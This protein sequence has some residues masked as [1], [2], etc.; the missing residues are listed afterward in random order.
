MVFNLAFFGECPSHQIKDRIKICIHKDGVV[1]TAPDANINTGKI[2]FGK[3]NANLNTRQINQL[4]SIPIR[5]ASKAWFYPR[6]SGCTKLTS[7]YILRF[8]VLLGLEVQQVG[9]NVA[10]QSHEIFHI[11]I[12]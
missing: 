9:V 12:I 8:Q 2:L 4:Y 3:K 5:D 6:P 11:T 10:L 1:L 7:G